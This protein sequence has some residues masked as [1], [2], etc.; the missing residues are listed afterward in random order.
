SYYSTATGSGGAVVD[1]SVGFTNGGMVITHAPTAASN[2][3]TY[4][5]TYA[6]GLSSTNYTFN[7][8]SSAVNYVVNPATITITGANTNTVYNGSA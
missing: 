3:A 4:A 7:P 6:N 1:P 2:A 5:L 8:A